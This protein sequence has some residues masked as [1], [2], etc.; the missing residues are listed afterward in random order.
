MNKEIVKE[1]CNKVSEFGYC[2]DTVSYDYQQQHN[3]LTISTV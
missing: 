1:Y 2:I 3:I